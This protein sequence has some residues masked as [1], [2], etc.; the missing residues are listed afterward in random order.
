MT[1]E[2][3]IEQHDKKNIAIPTC[4][5]CVNDMMYGTGSW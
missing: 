3:H 1:K 5:W 4:I 2:E